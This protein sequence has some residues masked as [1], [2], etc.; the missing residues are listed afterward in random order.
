MLIDLIKKE[1]KCFSLSY[2]KLFLLGLTV[3]LDSFSLGLG[4]RAITDNL[5]LSS[6]IFS[7]FAGLFTLFGIILGKY[8]SNKIG[9]YAK[10]FGIIL[11]FIIGISHLI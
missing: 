8:T 6:T 3:S 10:L 4:I 11:L 9:D 2:F 5:L 1:N 7:V